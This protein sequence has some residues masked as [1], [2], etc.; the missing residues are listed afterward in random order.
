MQWTA[1]ENAIFTE[2]APWNALYPDF[3]A[4]KNVADESTDPDSLL[5][6]YRKLIHL[7]NQHAALRVGDYF[8][9]QV[10]NEAIFSFLRASKEEAVLVVLNLGKDPI[11]GFNLSLD[12]GPLKEAYEPV[13]IF[14]ED[15]MTEGQ[16]LTSPAINAQGG[17]DSYRPILT[18][19]PLPANGSLIVQLRPIR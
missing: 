9:V 11:S 10:D 6:H 7:R 15:W 17:F 4:G 1:D 18:N 3:A 8:P 13:V 2:G 16:V 14:R 5:A 12:H 19:Q